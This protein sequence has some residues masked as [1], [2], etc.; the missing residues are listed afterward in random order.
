[1]LQQ[2]DCLDLQRSIRKEQLMGIEL[3]DYMF[4]IA[5]TN[6]ILR[7]DGKSNLHNFDFLAE[8]A[9]KLQKEIHCTVGMMNPPYSPTLYTHLLGSY[10]SQ[11]D[12][13]KSVV[14]SLL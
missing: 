6:M 5:T 11:L 10:K 1:M 3:Q 12:V 8:S 7:G 13:Q 2:T 14:L 9:S 4:T